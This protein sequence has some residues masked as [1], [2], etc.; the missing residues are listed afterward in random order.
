MAF[1]AGTL[2]TKSIVGKAVV[3]DVEGMKLGALVEGV[4]NDP[5]GWVIDPGM[6]KR[7]PVWTDV[8]SME[9]E[10]QSEAYVVWDHPVPAISLEG[11]MVP[12]GDQALPSET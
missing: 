12:V 8:R 2:P 3:E 4:L 6:Y 5:N 11:M 9:R 7:T 1:R 10:A